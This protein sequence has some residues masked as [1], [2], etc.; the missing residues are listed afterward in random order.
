MSASGAMIRASYAKT[1]I[2][3]IKRMPDGE[4][5]ALLNGI[6]DDLRSE[7][8]NYGMLE[9][10]PAARFVELVRAIARTVG[11]DGAKRFWRAN[12]LLSLERR[13]LSPLRLGAIAIYGNSPRSLLKM[14]PQAW[15]LVTRDGGTCHT[16]D[17]P[18]NSIVLR[19][20]ALPRELCDPAMHML[21][22]GGSESCIERMGFTGSA[23]AAAGASANSVDIT[24][25]WAPRQ[26]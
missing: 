17:R 25:N 26:P 23:Q 21:W 20:A 9:W 6:G 11:D 13:L 10:M 8:R 24:V 2:G 14:T 12:L 5:D 3:G 22:S 7:I 1:V 18:P 19:F 15:E 4:R 16:E